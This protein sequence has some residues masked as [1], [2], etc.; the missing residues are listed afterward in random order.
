MALESAQCRRDPHDIFFVIDGSAS[1]KYHNFE[2]VQLF[3]MDFISL[4]RVEASDINT[5]LLQFSQKDL[6]TFVWELGAYTEFDTIM[7]IRKM[8]YQA[9][10]HTSTGDA[11]T[12]VNNEVS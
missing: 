1:I 11:L 9:G 12:R 2:K 3:L 7:K 10:S 6:T 4:L 8:K 5:G